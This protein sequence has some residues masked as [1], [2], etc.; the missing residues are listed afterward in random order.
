MEDRLGWKCDALFLCGQ[1]GLNW[2]LTAELLRWRSKARNRLEQLRR[3]RLVE[4]PAE[5]THP[6]RTAPL[7][8]ILSSALRAYRGAKRLG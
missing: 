6:P 7:E 5:V 2:N 1:P 3:E 8:R 4:I